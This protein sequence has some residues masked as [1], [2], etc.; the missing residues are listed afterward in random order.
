MASFKIT[1]LKEVDL[2]IKKY[3]NTNKSAVIELLRSN[4]P[5]YFDPTE[6]T[7]LINYLDH[8][9]EDYFIVEE[10]S[11]IV[12]AGGINYFL[13]E[14]TARI[15][16][17]MIAPN[18]QGK[19]LGQHLIKYRIAHIKKNHLI[20]QIVVRT[21]QLVYQFYEKMGFELEE[22][23]KGYWAKNYDLYIMRRQNE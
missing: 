12:G 13:D 15:S 11:Q 18:A 23:V 16:W 14:K 19:G 17:D 9:R 5:E 3:S 4:T 2:E 8:E 6:E 20:D 22:I 10:N 21:S 1:P 7:D